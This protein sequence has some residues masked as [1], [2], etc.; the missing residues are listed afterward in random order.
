MYSLFLLKANLCQ[1]VL[2]VITSS[3]TR[4][5]WKSTWGLTQVKSDKLLKP[6]SCVEAVDDIDDLLTGEKPFTCEICGKC[7]TAKSTLQTHIR[8]HRWEVYFKAGA[9]RT[10]SYCLASLIDSCTQTVREQYSNSLH[11]ITCTTVC[12]NSYF[13]K[14]I[15]LQLNDN[16]KYPKNNNLLAAWY[17]KG[18]M[19][20]MR[21]FQLLLKVF[22]VR[23]HKPRSEQI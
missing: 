17:F 23:G 10:T 4:L 3:W 9:S 20:L 16:K 2:S 7:F 22:F 18:K 21:N 13:S 6:R 15:C 19:P 1:N 11:K 14:N 12:L 8:I 5:S